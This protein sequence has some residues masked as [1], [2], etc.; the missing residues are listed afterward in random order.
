MPCRGAIP[1]RC[2]SKDKNKCRAIATL[3]GNA[4][5]INSV[6][7]SPKGQTLASGSL[8]NTIKLWNP[9]TGELKSTLAGDDSQVNSFAFSPDG[10]IASG[11]ND[12]SIKIW[13]VPA[14]E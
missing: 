9:R 8:D 2:C 11:S 12:G 14:Q 4:T 7:F 10:Q 5:L 13:Q 1:V 3:K 6:A